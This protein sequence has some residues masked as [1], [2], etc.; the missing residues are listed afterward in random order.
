MIQ[1]RLNLMKLGSRRCAGGCGTGCSR[2]GRTHGVRSLG[3]HGVRS[4]RTHGVRSLRTHGIRSCSGG[5][6]GV[7]CCG[8][9]CSGLGGGASVQGCCHCDASDHA[10]Y[11]KFHVVGFQ[12]CVFCGR[13]CM[14]RHAR[15]DY[16]THGV[17]DNRVN[18][19]NI[20]GDIRSAPNPQL[21]RKQA[22]GCEGRS[23]RFGGQV[24]NLDPSVAWVSIAWGAGPGSGGPEG[25]EPGLVLADRPS[26]RRGFGYRGGRGAGVG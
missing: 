9:G 1:P 21:R 15:D 20:A 6:H 5:G 11:V 10:K 24:A 25:R 13:E 3:T 7:W 18:L 17:Y 22:M 4:L 8:F 14:R 16:D 12:E 19:E 2:S 26:G 23:S